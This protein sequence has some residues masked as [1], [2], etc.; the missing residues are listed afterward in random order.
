[1]NTLLHV[2]F[3]KTMYRLVVNNLVAIVVFAAT[4]GVVART[5]PEEVQARAR[6]I[7]PVHCL[8]ALLLAAAVAKLRRVG[9]PKDVY[10]VEYG[11]FRPKPWFRAPFA[12]CLEHA[13]LMPYLV[14]EESVS[15]AIRL[16]ERSGLGEETCVPDAYHYMPPDRSLSASRDETEL[17]I[18]SA[19]DEV[20]ARTSVKAEEIDV[21]IVNCS[22]FTPTPVFADMVV[23]RYKL[24][25]D[26]QNVNLSGMGCSAGLVSVGLAKNLLQTARPGTHVL[27]V[28]TEILSSQYYVG[29]E[30]AMLLPNCLFRMGAAAMI[31]SNSPERARYRLT[32]LVRTVTAA[33]DADYRCVFQEEDDK[34]NTGIRLSKDLAATAGHALKS[35]IA[36]FGPLVL[37]AS[38]QLLVA[39]SFL[40]RKLL[41][42]R[43][44]AKV[45]L[46]R[47]D[48]RTAFEHICIHAGGRGVIDEVQHGLGLSDEDVEASRMTL[49]RF[50]NT[51]SSSVLYELAYIEAK[52]AMKK[53]DR[54]WMISFG[55]GFDCNSVAWECVK[56]PA[57]AD[58]PWVDTIHRYPVQLPEIVNK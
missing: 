25:P 15:F 45:R 4:A 30:R 12:T 39:L 38:E 2:K 53:G 27:I 14:D 11:C 16:L 7:R 24:R 35:N 40:K 57:D 49:H 54:I 18:F 19:V 47:P 5:S 43:G 22:I 29:T 44:R 46:Y 34:G 58:G 6:E 20:F 23:N 26:V 3:L 10:L 42:L 55:A 9:R 56:P 37:P 8:L 33:R 41:L 13:H 31:L 21:L 32:R 1:M 51:S 48:F 36:A 50:G 17:V 28:S 52:G